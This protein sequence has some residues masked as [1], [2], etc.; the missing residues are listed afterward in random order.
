MDRIN[1]KKSERLGFFDTKG[2]D[3][4]K[5]G[6]FRKLHVYVDQSVKGY[7]DVDVVDPTVQHG[8]S[9]QRLKRVLTIQLSITEFKAFHIDLTKL[10]NGRYAAPLILGQAYHLRPGKS[11]VSIL[12]AVLDLI[13]QFA[14]GLCLS[15]LVSH[16]L[17]D[18]VYVL[19]FDP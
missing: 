18:F 8:R 12:D 4:V 6:S 11:F 2:P 10:W 15:F 13:W 16:A 9:P 17:V 19:A 7:I 1:M 5:I 3:Y 14:C